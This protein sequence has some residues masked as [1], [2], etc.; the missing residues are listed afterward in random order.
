MRGLVFRRRTANV[1]I[2]LASCGRVRFEPAPID[3]SDVD[4]SSGADAYVCDPALPFGAPVPIREINMPQVGEGTFRT[5]PDELGGYFWSYRGGAGSQ[6]KIYYASRPDLATPWTVQTTT[7]LEDGRNDLDPTLA[8][9][10]SVFVFR[11]NSPDDLYVATPIDATTFQTP[12]PIASINTLS[13]ET[14][15]F[16]QPNGN[17]LIFNSMRTGGGDL[18]RSTRTGTSFSAPT[19]I[20]GLSTLADEGDPVLGA[21]GL[22]L[23]FRRNDGATDY[24]I[25][26]A[27]RTS[28]AQPFGVGQLVE[29]V[30]AVGPAEGPSAVSE[31]GCR[32]YLTSDRSGDYDIYVATRGL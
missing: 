4:G 32:L 28:T 29:N 22:T 19:V 12:M 30:N 2:L 16:L 25:F 8:S 31:D 5:T 13:T 9:D 15:P 11:K 23:Y 27:T 24:D 26:V 3:A 10:G 1:L 17:E 14:E 21:D 7:G 6:A 18:Y 20:S